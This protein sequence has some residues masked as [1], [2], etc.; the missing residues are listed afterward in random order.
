[1][2]KVLILIVAVVF[3]VA[4]VSS[5]A[6]LP[7][8]AKQVATNGAHKLYSSTPGDQGNCSTFQIT[9]YTGDVTFSLHNYT[10]GTRATSDDGWHRLTLL[11]AR[12][13]TTLTLAEGET[14]VFE[15][16]NGYGPELYLISG[17]GQARVWAQ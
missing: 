15:F 10:K 4:A 2:K 7:K 16:S 11:E 8:W 13:D 5:A 14:A 6:G 9:A 17:G 3:L 1:M 12:G